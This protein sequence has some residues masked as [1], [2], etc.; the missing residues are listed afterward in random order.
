MI[1]SL[2]D[3]VSKL[4]RELAS[5]NSEIAQLKKQ[6]RYSQSIIS[7]RRKRNKELLEANKRFVYVQPLPEDAD[8]FECDVQY[9]RAI[10]SVSKLC[11]PYRHNNFK[12]KKMLGLL[13]SGLLVGAE[14]FVEKHYIK[15]TK[16]LMGAT[17]S[18]PTVLRMEDKAQQ[19]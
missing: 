9:C 19:G 11:F 7:K 5:K 6:Q 16:K 17:F 8:T 2:Q 15:F 3:K 14:T 1:M 18:P 10:V 4:E 12:A 13:E